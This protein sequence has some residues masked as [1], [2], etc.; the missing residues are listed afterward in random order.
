MISIELLQFQGLGI[1]HTGSYYQCHYKLGH[2][3]R[4]EP[5]LRLWVT[6]VLWFFSKIRCIRLQN[7]SWKGYQVDAHSDPPFK[8]IKLI[9]IDIV[10]LFHCSV[11]GLHKTNPATIS[12]C[13]M[14][15]R[16]ASH[17]HGNLF[18]NFH[19]SRE[20]WMRHDATTTLCQ[21]NEKNWKTLT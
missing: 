18:H 1:V 13:P 7:T 4:T 15:C 17:T 2:L 12:S 8:V 21:Q 6:H 9:L 20:T 14:M 16:V 10:L 5:L 3:N 19:P 11:F